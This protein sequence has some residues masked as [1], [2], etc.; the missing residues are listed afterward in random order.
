MET[1][2]CENLLRAIF[3][4]DESISGVSP[5]IIENGR[6]I[7]IAQ[8]VDEALASLGLAKGKHDPEPWERCQKI[9]RARFGIGDKNHT[10]SQIAHD[11]DITSARVQQL[12]K[13]SL[14][15]LRHHSRSAKLKLFLVFTPVKSEDNR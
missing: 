1:T 15:R 5:F 14:R 11:M 9:L 3:T 2:G 13:K 4:I 10:Q 6:E 8:A 7:P 12:L